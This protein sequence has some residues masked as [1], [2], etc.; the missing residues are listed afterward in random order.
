MSVRL[1]THEATEIITPLQKSVTSETESSRSTPE[2]MPGDKIKKCC[3]DLFGNELL[4]KQIS[5]LFKVTANTRRRG[6]LSTPGFTWNVLK[7]KK[8]KL[9][10]KE[11]LVTSYVMSF[12]LGGL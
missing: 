12:C 11:L 3:D 10:C 4:K 8:S 7:E 6:E 5:K 2:I 1:L 9:K